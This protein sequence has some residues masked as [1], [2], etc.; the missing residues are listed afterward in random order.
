MRGPGELRFAEP[1]LEKV[2]LV[3][4]ADIQGHVYVPIYPRQP[5]SAQPALRS[6]CLIDQCRISTKEDRDTAVKRT[7]RGEMAMIVPSKDQ[8]RVRPPSLY[9]RYQRSAL[10][11]GEMMG[12]RIAALIRDDGER[13]AIEQRNIPLD[14]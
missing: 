7:Q 10:Q 5:P 13:V 4:G 14:D 11:A 3:V 8:N 12:T 2:S 1:V 6:R 9:R